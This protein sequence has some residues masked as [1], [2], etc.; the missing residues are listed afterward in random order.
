MDIPITII[1]GYLGAGK[2]TL[3]NRVLNHEGD[4]SGLAVLVNDFGDVNIDATLIRAIK[5][6]DQVFDLTNGCVCC[7]IQDDFSA[8]LEALQNR[9]IKTCVIRS[10]RC[11]FTGK[12]KSPMQLSR[13][14]PDK[15]VRVGGRHPTYATKKGQVH[16][17]SGAATS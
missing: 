15:C 9:D 4:L 10:Q 6:D 11:C 5:K 13:L 17:P 8:S 12:V 2:T 3:I 16:R 14:S 7:T 1:A